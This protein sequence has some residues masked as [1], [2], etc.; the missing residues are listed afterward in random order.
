MV[1]SGNVVSGSILV[2]QTKVRASHLSRP[3]LSKLNLQTRCK[4]QSQPSRPVS[5]M[6]FWIRFSSRSRLRRIFSLR[7]AFVVA[8]AV[9]YASSGRGKEE[10]NGGG[11]GS[12]R[13]SPS[14]KAKGA[15]GKATVELP[16]GDEQLRSRPWLFGF[17]S[18][19]VQGCD[20]SSLCLSPDEGTG[21]AP[22]PAPVIKT[23]PADPVQDS[24]PALKTDP[25]DMVPVS[26]QL[27][28][29]GS[30]DGWLSGLRN[31]VMRPSFHGCLWQ[32]SFKFNLSAHRP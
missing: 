8:S 11:K 10:V 23:E 12:P 25:E 30:G 3:R 19:L 5:A 15:A 27:C 9:E 14:T 6:A 32:R 22:V 4:A 17:V 2:P 21:I 29:V 7:C 13:G 18:L 28:R 31:W 16:F 26:L 20:E 24:E 1:A